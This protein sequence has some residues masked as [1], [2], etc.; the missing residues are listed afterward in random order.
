M[1]HKDTGTTAL[2]ELL[3]TYIEVSTEIINHVEFYFKI[4]GIV[5]FFESRKLN[6][7]QSNRR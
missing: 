5:T 7:N 2:A 4:H 3:N 6:S 1:H